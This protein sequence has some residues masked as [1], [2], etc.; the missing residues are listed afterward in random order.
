MTIK[1]IIVDTNKYVELNYQ[2]FEKQ[3]K[4]K[5]NHLTKNQSGYDYDYETYGEDLEYIQS[6]DPRYVWTYIQGDMSMLMVN[7]VAFV[8]RISYT[9]CENPWDE[10]KDY[11]VLISVDTECDCY[12]EE[13]DVMES[14]NDEYGD[15]ACEECEGS[16]YKTEWVN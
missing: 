5:L 4:P 15:P 10:D 16:G 3:F 2:E 12:S 7:G 13:D 6:L 14:R 11:T 8:N 1:P 9:V